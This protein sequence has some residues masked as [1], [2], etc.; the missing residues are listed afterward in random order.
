ML[1]LI[2]IEGFIVLNVG[3][4]KEAMDVEMEN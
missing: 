1:K 4:L 3:V 2:L